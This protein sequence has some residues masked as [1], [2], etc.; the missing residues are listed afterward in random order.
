MNIRYISVVNVKLHF[1]FIISCIWRLKPRFCAVV[2]IAVVA[3]DAAQ[4]L[5]PL[6]CLRY[7]QFLV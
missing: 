1:S 3:L 4:V 6:L 5:S 7:P 2:V